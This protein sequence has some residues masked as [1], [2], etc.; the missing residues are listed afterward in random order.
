MGMNLT[1]L[2]ANETTALWTVIKERMMTR[3]EQR[4]ISW[5]VFICVC[6]RSDSLEVFSLYL[7]MAAHVCSLVFKCRFSDET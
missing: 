4:N 2:G 5:Q 3:E 7:A 1:L 6:Q